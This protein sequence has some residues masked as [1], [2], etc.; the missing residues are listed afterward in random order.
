MA[1]TITVQNLIDFARSHVKLFPLVGIGS[2][3]NEPGLSFANMIKE[4]IINQNYNWRWNRAA[5]PPFNTVDGQ[6]DYPIVPASLG[7]LEKARIERVGAGIPHQSIRHLKVRRTLELGQFKSDPQY[8]ALERAD[9]GQLVIRLEPI[10]STVIWT[11]Y[12]FYQ[13]APSKLIALGNT[14]DPIPDQ[15]ETVLKQ[16][17]VAYAY[18]LVDRRRHLEELAIAEKLLKDKKATLEPEESMSV[19]TPD[20]S[21]FL[22]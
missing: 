7:W 13:K 15:F 5:L 2:I 19:F 3:S 21:L 8:I 18:G 1:S 6:S 17:F 9:N 14:F 22:G 12:P 11:V 16:Y 4:Q 10:P 20:R